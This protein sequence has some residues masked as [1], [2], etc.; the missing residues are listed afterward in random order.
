MSDQTETAIELT[1]LVIGKLEPRYRNV[2]GEDPKEIR[3][4]VIETF[5]ECLKALEADNTPAMP[6]G[7]PELEKV[8]DMLPP[9]QQTQIADWLREAQA[10]INTADPG[11]E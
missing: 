9:E 2:K 7:G 5:R 4:V 3:E 1:K 10:K 11:K 6:M 8:L